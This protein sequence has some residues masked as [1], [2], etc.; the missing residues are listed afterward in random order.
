MAGSLVE[1]LSSLT[2]IRLLE[3][4]LG[5]E[6]SLELLGSA[7]SRTVAMTVVLERAR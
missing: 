5:R 2:T 1:A 7:G 4:L 6:E 3:E